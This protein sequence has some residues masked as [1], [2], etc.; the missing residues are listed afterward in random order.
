MSGVKRI[1]LAVVFAAAMW[2]LIVVGVSLFSG[3]KLLFMPQQA[4]LGSAALAGRAEVLRLSFF[5]LYAYF[6]MLHIFVEKRKISAGHVLLSIM[7]SLTLVGTI[8]LVTLDDFP[9]EA[10]YVVLFGISALLIFLGSRPS[11]RR[12]FKRRM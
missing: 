9:S 2:S 10:G 12:Y 8:K 4:D 5:L 6:A 7:T 11:V 3:D 1:Y